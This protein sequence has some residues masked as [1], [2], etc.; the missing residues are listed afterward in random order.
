M[1]EL[2][3]QKI[4]ESIK[5]G[6]TVQLSILRVLKGEIERKEQDVKK[7]KV[8]V[9][10]AEIMK[11]IKQLMLSSTP[12]E[13]VYLE[14]LLPEQMSEEQM[15]DEID[16]MFL[17]ESLKMVGMKSIGIVNRHFERVYSGQYDNNFVVSYT[18]QKLSE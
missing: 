13:V 16:G 1:K 18:K 17:Q 7:G 11:I 6:S 9:S 10:D 14:S 2:I 3:T 15:K 8:D 12:E 5:F 4:K